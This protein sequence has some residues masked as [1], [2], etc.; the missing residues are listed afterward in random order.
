MKGEREKHKP[1]RKRGCVSSTPSQKKLR[2]ASL[3]SKRTIVRSE[4]G[5]EKR[6]TAET[7]GTRAKIATHINNEIC[8]GGAKMR[9]NYCEWRNE[10]THNGC[11]QQEKQGITNHKSHNFA[12][13]QI[14]CA[15]ERFQ[16]ICRLHGASSQQT[17]ALPEVAHHT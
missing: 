16:T 5:T 13:T 7:T 4:K 8:S 17:S 12:R 9:D 15:D 1:P 11:I 6:E 10:H 2:K 3:T 14:T